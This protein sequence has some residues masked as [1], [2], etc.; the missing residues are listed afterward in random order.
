MKLER[1][2]C[3][4]KDMKRL[5]DTLFIVDVKKERI[6]FHEARKLNI[7]VI[8]VVDTNC[9][10]DDVDYIIPGNDD[11]IRS[12]RLFT[13]R[14]AEAVLEGQL[15]FKK[16]EEEAQLIKEAERKLEEQRKEASKLE[17][18]AAGKK[19]VGARVQRA[20][21]VKGRTPRP[22]KE[23]DK[24][25]RQRINKASPPSSPA[26]T[27]VADREKKQAKPYTNKK[28]QQKKAKSSPENRGKGAST[29]THQ[30]KNKNS[31]KIT[32]QIEPKTQGSE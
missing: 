7:P 22:K 23:P 4:V 5:P 24:G 28:I 20:K 2:L 3:G 18:K 11:A 26:K 17:K 27:A 14:I 29:S 25:A 31:K 19:R 30:E 13:S 9:D 16:K 6:A 1:L 12:I 8:G 10:P 32:R 15:L 21:A